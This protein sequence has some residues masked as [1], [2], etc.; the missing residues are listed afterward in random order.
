MENIDMNN[1]YRAADLILKCDFEKLSPGGKIYAVSLHLDS[2]IDIVTHLE[3]I[4]VDEV[5]DGFSDLEQEERMKI[6]SL[7]LTELYKLKNF[8]FENVLTILIGDSV[9]DTCDSFFETIMETIK[10]FTNITELSLSFE[11]VPRGLLKIDDR[12]NKTSL[13][14]LTISDYPELIQLRV[15][16]T[17]K[18]L[19][20]I[21]KI[22]LPLIG[23]NSYYNLINSKSIK[24]LSFSIGT[25]FKPIKTSNNTLKDLYVSTYLSVESVKQI[26][27]PLKAL[28]YLYI[29]TLKI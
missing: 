8:Y 10:S 26:A 25:V 9:I 18:N 7:A 29:Q 17:S 2:R 13:R 11:S 12:I 15:V 6:I 1:M 14:S 16:V 23:E 20:K 3:C 4:P 22:S 27:F 21:E 19:E 24:T 5:F 28:T